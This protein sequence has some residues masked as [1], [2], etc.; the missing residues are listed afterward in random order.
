MS[1][2]SVCAGGGGESVLL[3]TVD[4]SLTWVTLT[5]WPGSRARAAGGASPGAG[6]QLRLPKAKTPAGAEIP[7]SKSRA[8]LGVGGAAEPATPATA[9]GPIAKPSRQWGL[10]GAVMEKE[11]LNLE[12]MGWGSQIS[13]PRAGIWGVPH[14]NAGGQRGAAPQGVAGAAPPPPSR[15]RRV[16]PG[17]PILSPSCPWRRLAPSPK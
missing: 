1:P 6:F 8:L 5:G 10:L 7:W 4:G 9:Q 16:P 12:G 3:S 14:P 17:R 13:N 2:M 11:G 15:G